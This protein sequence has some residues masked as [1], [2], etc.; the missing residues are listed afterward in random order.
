[1]RPRPEADMAAGRHRD[2]RKGPHLALCFV[3]CSSLRS[4]FGT[5][6]SP[7]GTCS[8]TGSLYVLSGLRG[9]SRMDAYRPLAQVTIEQPSTEGVSQSRSLELLVSK[10]S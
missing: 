5:V 7:S 3:H 2:R 9:V 4:R 8:S 10:V 1:M 6:P